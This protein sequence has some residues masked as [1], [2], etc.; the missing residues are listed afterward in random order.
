LPKRI[1]VVGAGISGLAAAHRIVELA[2]QCEVRLYEKQ[3]RLGGVLATVHEQGYQVELSAD[4]FITTQPWGLELVRRLG[5]GAELM[6]TNPACRRTFVM[7]KRRLY[8]LPDGFL[9]MAPTKMWPMAVTPV[10]SPVGKLR[11]GLEY[12]LPPSRDDRDESMAAFVRR[13][14]GREVFERLVEPLVSGVYAA[15]ME[16]LS[17]LA[18]LPRFREMERK[19]GSLIRA[20][21]KQMKA[22][23]AAG[24]H[25]DQS[26]ARY[27][28]FVTLERGLSSL[29]DALAARLPKAAVR[30]GTNVV[31]VEPS[32]GGWKVETCDGRS[33]RFDALILATPSHVA[34]ELLKP[35]A[36]ELSGD[37]AGIE[38][39]GTAIVTMAFESSQV[40]HPM[41][42]AGFVVPAIEGSPI[43][44][45]SFSSRKYTHR[46]P[47][48][49]TLI[50]TFV[51]GARA[52]E[53]AEM[54]DEK[55][56]PLVLEELR[57]VLGI[58]GGPIYQ[59]T[60]HWP[61]TM[62]QYHVGHLDLVARIERRTGALAGLALAG[63][64]YGGVG[65]PACIHSG[66]QAA[67][68]LL[69]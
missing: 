10:L 37:L 7:R 41:H 67:A 65:I 61:R 5:L 49:K 62:P 32:G 50:R 21:R 51:G 42:G 30:L 14:L 44:A 33:D 47:D 53:M 4:N 46:A 12:F 56:V 43:L 57:E 15:D 28:M 59:V 68:K 17:L 52:P 64:A 13:R 31:R 16:K 18:T 23:R 45:G 25:V 63:N 3:D 69:G 22:A 40:K 58:S 6:Q 54:A 2:P 35:V 48:G 29:I 9:M 26:G 11:A 20:M 8:S 55:L 39:E 60:A 38:H 24:R 66:E 19:H 34:A 1:A 27:S 36:A